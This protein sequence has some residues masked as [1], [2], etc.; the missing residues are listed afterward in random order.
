MN[1]LRTYL[2]N[3][4]KNVNKVNDIEVKQKPQ[5]TICITLSPSLIQLAKTYKGY[6]FIKYLI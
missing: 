4:L 2:K 6:T 5:I 3:L 1:L